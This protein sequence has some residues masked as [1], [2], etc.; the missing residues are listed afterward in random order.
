MGREKD[1]RVKPGYDDE[2]PRAKVLA[3][4]KP[5]HSRM[6]RLD[7]GILLAPGGQIAC[8]KSVA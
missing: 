4:M 3:E 1:S 6:P 2:I 5:A 8:I 7:R